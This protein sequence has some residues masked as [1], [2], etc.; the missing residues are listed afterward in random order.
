MKTLVCKGCGHI[1]F[2]EAPEKC[3]VCRSPKTAY[4]EKSDAIQK[5]ANPAALTE[6]DKKHIPQI[7]VVKECGLI[8]GG[9]CTDVHARVGEIEHVMQ[10]KHYIRCLDYYVDYKF[11]SRVW[12]S[13]NVCH[14]AAALHLNVKGGTVTVIENCNVHGNWMAEAKL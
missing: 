8:P 13:P 2:N 1:E 3:L 10:D 7:V 11:I 14:P 6:G 4:E 12:L 5:P 9:C